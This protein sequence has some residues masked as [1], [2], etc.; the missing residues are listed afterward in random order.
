MTAVQRSPEQYPS[1]LV[2]STKIL[3]IIVNCYS[4]CAQHQPQLFNACRTNA[5]LSNLFNHLRARFAAIIER[6]II[7]KSLT[8]TETAQIRE[9][10]STES[11]EELIVRSA[12]L[13]K[14]L[15]SKTH[16][17]LR[18]SD[19]PKHEEKRNVIV[20]AHS[21]LGGEA[22]LITPAVKNP[23][24]SKPGKIGRDEDS[25]SET[26][27]RYHF[28]LQIIP[29]VV[30]QFQ[31]VR[32]HL[33]LETN[34][35]LAKRLAS[36]ALKI[37]AAPLNED[38]TPI[39]EFP[40][41]FPPNEPK[42][43]VFKAIEKEQTQRECVSRILE[44]C[45]QEHISVLVLPELRTPPFLRELVVETLR[46]QLLENLL[47]GVGLL[48]VVCGSWHIQQDGVFKNQSV[49]LDRLGNELWTHDKLAEFNLTKENVEKNT[50]FWSQ[51]GF[52]PQGGVEDIRTGTSLQICDCPLGRIAV[53]IC[54]GFFHHPIERVLIKSG[55]TLFLVPTMSPDVRPIKERARAL[56]PTQ[57]ATVV[58][59]NCAHFGKAP[60]VSFYKLPA[61]DKDPVDIPAGA[62]LCVLDI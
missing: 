22:F 13:L 4:F 61:K 60:Q 33:S 28:P 14:A 26:L 62:D 25:I 10:L 30:D 20:A 31:I 59:A 27:Q 8:L 55:V 53:A 40:A 23:L 48:L 51:L 39:L 24:L 17:I 43:Y 6:E 7:E 37:A 32:K 2:G 46:S 44:E 18:S 35:I 36:G 57:R 50:E 38:I 1:I 5:R 41:G 3:E 42:R 56:A 21:Q 19:A 29:E 16:E 54:V 34:T 12:A 15:A 11:M 47:D 52:G 45:R 9:L 58:V 49:I